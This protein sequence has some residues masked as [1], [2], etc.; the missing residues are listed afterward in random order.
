M[1]TP[2]NAVKTIR[3]ELACLTYTA[4]KIKTNFSKSWMSRAGDN[5]DITV[6]LE[7]QTRSKL[8]YI[9]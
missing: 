4:S 5:V 3:F 2:F 9:L 6:K 8:E 7:F 1:K